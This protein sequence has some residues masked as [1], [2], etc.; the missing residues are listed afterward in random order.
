[1]RT[2]VDKSKQD[3]EQ[4]FHSFS[5]RFQHKSADKDLIMKDVAIFM[6]QKADLFNPVLIPVILK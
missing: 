3:Y 1:M 6:E 4:I 2:P 5:K